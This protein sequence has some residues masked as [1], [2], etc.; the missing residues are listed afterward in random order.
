MPVE[1]KGLRETY[2]AARLYK[3][4]K[5]KRI[6]LE[7][8]V[9]TLDKQLSGQYE[10]VRE[11]ESKEENYKTVISSLNDINKAEQKKTKI[12]ADAKDYWNKKFRKQV[13]KTRWV[14]AG[15][16]VVTV[17]TAILTTFLLK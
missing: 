3:V 10:K 6:E 4:E 13:N 12:E 11:L 8:K 2:L 1:V 14:A 16:I 5:A 7:S 17:G 15:G 9:T